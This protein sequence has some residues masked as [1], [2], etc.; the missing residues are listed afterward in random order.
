MVRVFWIAAI[1]LIVT[2]PGSAS[3]CWR[4]RSYP[5]YGQPVLVYQGPTGT[6]YGHT[7]STRYVGTYY[8]PYRFRSWGY[9]GGPASFRA[10]FP[11]IGFGRLGRIGR[12]R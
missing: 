6:W 11:R 4:H 10:S 12:I 2:I 5:S 8:R 7:G 3:A 1:A 9:Y